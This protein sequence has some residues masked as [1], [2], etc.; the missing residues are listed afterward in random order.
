MASTTQLALME[1]ETPVVSLQTEMY[2]QYTN[3]F[4]NIIAKIFQLFAIIFG[5]KEWGQLT[6]TNKRIVIEKHS[7]IFWAFDKG[8]VFS[9]L[10]P[11]TIANVDYA[12]K[13]QICCF[14][15]KYFF[16][17]SLSSGTTYGFV[18]TGGKNQAIEITNAA[19]STLLSNTR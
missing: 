2:A 7:K 15:P 4:A 12:F 14:C 3:L 11:H 16:T 6:I 1:G 5:C 17:I 18:L 9:T 19:V 10:M 8:A 13:G